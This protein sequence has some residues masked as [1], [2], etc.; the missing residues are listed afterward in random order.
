MDT[1]GADVT[2]VDFGEDTTEDDTDENI[3]LFTDFAT[4]GDTVNPVMDWALSLFI[5]TEFFLVTLALVALE[6]GVLGEF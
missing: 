1:L 5:L 4:L 2:D 3:E 6:L